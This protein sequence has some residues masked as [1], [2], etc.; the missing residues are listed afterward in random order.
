MTQPTNSIL[1]FHQRFLWDA[2][3]PGHLT[4]SLFCSVHPCASSLISD[5]SVK[6][7]RVCVC[8]CGNKI[9]F[10]YQFHFKRCTECTLHP[11]TH[12]HGG[13]MDDHRIHISH[14]SEDRNN[15]FIQSI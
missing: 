10:D 2:L 15:S 11:H 13:W 12:S 7:Y 3:S 14:Q 1:F 8:V 6:K 4:T 9:K 5:S